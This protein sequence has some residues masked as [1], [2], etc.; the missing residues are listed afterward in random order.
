M[1]M[2]PHKRVHAE[3]VL[4]NTICDQCLDGR[5]AAGMQVSS[6]RVDGASQLR[7]ASWQQ[8]QLVGGKCEWRGL[9]IR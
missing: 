8:Y 7:I 1:T 4:V 9:H 3:Y 5:L 6:V 2:R